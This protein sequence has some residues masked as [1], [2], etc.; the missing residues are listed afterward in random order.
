MSPFERFRPTTKDR[1]GTLVPRIGVWLAFLVT[2]SACFPDT[3]FSVNYA[4]EFSKGGSN[5]SV[6]GVFTDGQMSPR[7]WEYLRR[8]LSAPFNEDSCVAVYG[9]ELVTSAPALSAAVDEYARTS[10][11]TDDLLDQF[12]PMAKGDTI[13]LITVAGR[14]PQAI[15]EPSSDSQA[16]SKGSVRRKGQGSQDPM[17]KKKEPT[18]QNVFEVSASFFSIRLHRSVALVDMTYSGSRTDEAVK[19]FAAKL[20]TELRGSTC[21]GWSSDVRVDDKRIH[22]MVER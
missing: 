4:P 13:M 19:G 6:F 3:G 11:V 9:D 2:C 18:D 20:E 21:S 10:G 7:A 14:P 22:D 5:I 8:R 12:A 1:L 15:D 17:H 16:T